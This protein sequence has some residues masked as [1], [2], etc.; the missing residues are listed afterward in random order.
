MGFIDYM[1]LSDLLIE[2]GLTYYSLRKDKV[3]GTETIKKLQQNKGNIDTRTIAHICEY[4]QCQPGD[5][6]KYHNEK[7]YPV[8]IENEDGSFSRN[9][10]VIEL[11][12]EEENGQ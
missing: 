7:R 4:L 10:A 1:E 12:K 2:R 6:L 8:Y 9:P 3:V 5:F 11:E